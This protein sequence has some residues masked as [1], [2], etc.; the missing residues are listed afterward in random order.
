MHISLIPNVRLGLEEIPYD[1]CVKTS[2][3]YSAIRNKATAGPLCFRL[4]C[5]QSW[6]VRKL[7]PI[8]SANSD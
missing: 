4:L 7:T 3:C 5:S 6:T 1:S 2:G 8:K